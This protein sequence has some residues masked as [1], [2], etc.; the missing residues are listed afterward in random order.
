MMNHRV[1]T[2]FTEA[3]VDWYGQMLAEGLARFCPIVVSQHLKAADDAL[4]SAVTTSRCP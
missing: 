2:E 3:Q 1:A 4:H